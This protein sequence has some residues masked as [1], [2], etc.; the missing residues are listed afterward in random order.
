MPHRIR[1]LLFTGNE[2]QA[3]LSLLRS[4]RCLYLPD[5]TG[6]AYNP[7]AQ[8]YFFVILPSHHQQGK[9]FL[10]DEPPALGTLVIS[11]MRPFPKG[12][13]ASFESPLATRQEYGII[14][15][16]NISGDEK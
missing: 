13:I 15:A 3:R 14:T 11:I 10:A 2:L 9:A 12:L 5:Y 16:I 6:W 1:L 4:E 8:E 7:S